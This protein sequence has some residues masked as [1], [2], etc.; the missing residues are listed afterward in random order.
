MRAM[1]GV[2]RYHLV[3]ALCGL[4]GY[5]LATGCIPSLAKRPRVS[6][7]L[8]HGHAAENLA[9]RGGATTLQVI[10]TRVLLRAASSL[11]YN[12]QKT[13]MCAAV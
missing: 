10:M 12:G 7:R 4:V 8:A 13:S 9:W 6:I 11:S 1:Y 3:Q 5:T 2:I